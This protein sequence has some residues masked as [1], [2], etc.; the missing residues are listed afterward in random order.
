[1]V[2]MNDVYIHIEIIINQI[3]RIIP[4]TPDY[5]WH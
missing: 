4:H 1:M 5:E 3:F 2:C